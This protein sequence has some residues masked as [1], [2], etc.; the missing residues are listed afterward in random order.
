MNEAE[1]LRN[2]YVQILFFSKKE[3]AACDLQR[4]I[5]HR[6]EPFVAKTVWILFHHEKTKVLHTVPVSILV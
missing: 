3:N 2:I 4:Q 6:N 5:E 1:H